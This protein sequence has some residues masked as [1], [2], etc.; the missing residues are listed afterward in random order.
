MWIFGYSS[1][2]WY[3]GFPYRNVVPG[4]VRGYSR[5]FWQLS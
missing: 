4:V 5:R 3:T 1:L 2:L